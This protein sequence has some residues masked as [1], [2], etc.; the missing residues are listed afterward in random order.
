MRLVFSEMSSSL[1]TLTI[2]LDVETGEQYGKEWATPSG[3][4]SMLTEDKTTNHFY[5]GHTIFSKN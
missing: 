4:K 3:L 2:L 1:L 5:C